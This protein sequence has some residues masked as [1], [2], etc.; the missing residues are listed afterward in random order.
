MTGPQFR[1]RAGRLE[2]AAA[3]DGHPVAEALGRVQ[4]MRGQE[5]GPPTRGQLGDGGRI[6]R[7]PA[8]SRP[9]VGSSRMRTRG[10]CKRASA[11]ASRFFIPS[12]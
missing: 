5:D 2:D 4:E 12:E 9:F 7:A 3:N 10:S 11:K 1:R 8:G 6:W